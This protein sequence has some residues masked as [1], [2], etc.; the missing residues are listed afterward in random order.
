MIKEEIT[1]MSEE[2]I[3]FSEIENEFRKIENDEKEKKKKEI[4]KEIEK[5]ARKRKKVNKKKTKEEIK[6][7]LVCRDIPKEEKD[8]IQFPLKNKNL[9]LSKSL[10]LVFISIFLF[11]LVSSIFVAFF[12]YS[13]INEK[14]K[15]T[16]N[17][18]QPINTTINNN[19][20]TGCPI[21]SLDCGNQTFNITLT[22]TFNIDVNST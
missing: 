14:F 21:C 2:P 3:N 12:G 6:K 17:I 11:L 22:P 13:A 8:F 5:E 7:E 15:S 20:T 18:Q 10:V 9:V 4:L 16:F 19:I 1:K